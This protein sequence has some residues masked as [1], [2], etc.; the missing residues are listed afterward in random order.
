MTV[1]RRGK[2]CTS[3][4]LCGD[5]A[6]ATL[7]GVRGYE[8]AR[9]RYSRFRYSRDL[10]FYYFPLL[11]NMGLLPGSKHGAGYILIQRSYSVLRKRMFVFPGPY[12]CLLAKCETPWI[13]GPKARVLY[14]LG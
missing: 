5:A 7:V 3:L 10:F 6:R 1:K 4:S 2:S 8:L 12:G 9:F 14:A 13:A 11:G